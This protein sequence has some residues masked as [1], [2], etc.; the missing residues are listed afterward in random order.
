MVVQFVVL[1][2]SNHSM[3]VGENSHSIAA[4]AML[5]YEGCREGEASAAEGDFRQNLQISRASWAFHGDSHPFGCS[6]SISGVSR[7]FVV[8]IQS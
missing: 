8:D 6:L 7:E 4:D 2:Q 5:L 3:L 1:L